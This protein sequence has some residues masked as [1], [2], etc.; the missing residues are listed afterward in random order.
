MDANFE[1]IER[2]LALI[3]VHDMKDAG[4]AEKA[5]V[6][7]KA[8]FSNS[9]IAVLLGAKAAV[10]AQQL[11][12]IRRGGSKKRKVAKKKTSKKK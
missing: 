7:S 2:L 11:Y 5:L 6:L 12:E 10:I 1:R 4:Q 9:E 8:A 3:L